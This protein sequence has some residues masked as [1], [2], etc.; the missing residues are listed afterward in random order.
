LCWQCCFHQ[1][2]SPLAPHLEGSDGRATRLAVAEPAC[3]SCLDLLLQEVHRLS[4]LGPN[5]GGFVAH[6]VPSGI[7]LQ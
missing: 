3:W 4:F 1:N 2:T 5:C 7:N 6:I